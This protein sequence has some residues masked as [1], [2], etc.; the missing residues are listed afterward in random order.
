MPI[1]D[2]DRPAKAK[3]CSDEFKRT[4]AMSWQGY[5]GD[6]DWFHPWGQVS[7]IPSASARDWRNRCLLSWG[8][9]LPG[10]EG[11][12]SGHLSIKHY[13]IKLPINKRD[14]NAVVW[15]TSPR[16]DASSAVDPFGP[17]VIVASR[18]RAS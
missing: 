14:H 8:R 16:I 10:S 12:R 18:T 1:K 6:R 7:G 11:H 5:P 2:P 4:G 9:I 3:V 13:L 17:T 15:F